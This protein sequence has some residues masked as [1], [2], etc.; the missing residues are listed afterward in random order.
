MGLYYIVMSTMPLQSWDG[1]G[2]SALSQEKNHNFI[3]FGISKRLAMVN[4]QGGRSLLAWMA[5]MV[6]SK[7]SL[8]L[9]VIA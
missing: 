5:I 2:M 4:N 3:V 1:N 8:L 9:C 6:R 7:Q